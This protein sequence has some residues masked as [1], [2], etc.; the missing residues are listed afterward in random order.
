MK[1]KV[2]S[3]ASSAGRPS[4]RKSQPR[5]SSA[6]APSPADKAI[7]FRVRVA[8]E[9][10]ARMRARLLSA[11]MDVCAVATSQGPAVID[12]VIRAAKVS[13]GTFYKHFDSLEQALVELGAK[14]ADETVDGLRTMFEK[15]D[16][17]LH[18][19][20]S[21]PQLMMIHAIV[22]PIWG[23][24]VAHTDHLTSESA[25]ISAIREN[26]IVGRERG[27]FRYSSLE[28]AIDLQFGSTREG[29]RHMITARADRTGYMQDLCA[30]NLMALGVTPKRAVAAVRSASD[31]IMLRGP[32]SLTWWKPF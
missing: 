16:D 18:R 15:V 19:T 4:T 13:R 12:D 11:T 21:G 6:A 10:R 29:V 32:T 22:D 1:K 28:A 14:L 8:R 7:N 23:R 30:M 3:D 26:T 5:S 25:F 24:F 20:A 31:D 27:I 9:R 17:P 2:S